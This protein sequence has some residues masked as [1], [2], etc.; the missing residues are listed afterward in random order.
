MK[1]SEISS[2][3]EKHPYY[4]KLSDSD[5]LSV[6][7]ISLINYWNFKDDEMTH[8]VVPNGEIGWDNVAIDNDDIYDLAQSD[9]GVTNL[10]KYQSIDLDLSGNEYLKVFSEE[11]V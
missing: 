2:V 7:N 8:G 1:A 9:I 5:K 10:S 6:L 4:A 3:L 11:S